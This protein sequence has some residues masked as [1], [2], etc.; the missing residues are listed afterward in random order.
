MVGSKTGLGVAGGNRKQLA[1]GHS[2]KDHDSEDLARIGNLHTPPSP[3][4]PAV[5]PGIHRGLSLPE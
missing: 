1:N 3:H 4:I 2:T 5:L